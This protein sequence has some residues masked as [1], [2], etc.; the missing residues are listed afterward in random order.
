MGSPHSVGSTFKHPVILF[1]GVCNLCNG[2]VQFVINRD[3]REKFRFASLQSTTGKSYLKQFKLTA[4][5][6]SII[7]IKKE[8]VFDKSSAALEIAKDLSGLWPAFYAFKIVPKYVRDKIYDFVAG[9]R[10]KWFGKKDEC[11]IPTPELKT[12]FLE[13]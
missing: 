1:D 11:M 3:A 5:V 12:R 4:D 10:Y 2:A 13:P 9:H 7:L 6:Y 8:R